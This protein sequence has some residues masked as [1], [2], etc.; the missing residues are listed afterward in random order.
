MVNVSQR[1]EPSRV[2]P[3]ASGPSRSR[4]ALVRNIIYHG[5]EGYSDTVDPRGR[6]ALL[7][8]EDIER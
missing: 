8:Y 7:L 3:Q 1:L 4:R 2:P 6:C 5:W